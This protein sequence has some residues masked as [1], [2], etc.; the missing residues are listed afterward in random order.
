MDPREMPYLL[1]KIVNRVNGKAYVGFTKNTL[2]WRI[3]AHRY[4]PNPN[5]LIH[6]AIKK[7]GKDAF[8]VETIGTASNRQQAAALERELIAAH[9]TFMPNGYNMTPGGEGNDAPRSA[10]TRSRMKASWYPRQWSEEAKASRLAKM[11]GRKHPQE[12]TERQRAK[13]IG[14]K[15]SPEMRAKMRAIGLNQTPE[16]LARI[17]ESRRNSRRKKIEEQGQITLDL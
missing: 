2:E 11:T 17:I 1:Y 14:Q 4:G 13:M 9:N 5:A 7:Y 6:K 15:R 16:K 10:E 12:Q 8:T 3:K